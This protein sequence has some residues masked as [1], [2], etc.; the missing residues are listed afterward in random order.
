VLC[1]PLDALR[2]NRFHPRVLEPTP[3]LG[4][5]STIGSRAL[6]LRQLKYFVKVVETGNMTRAA[7]QIFVAQPAL[8]MQ[9]RQLEEDLG[10]ALLERHSRGVSP[11]RAGALLDERARAILAL[12]EDT[13]REVSACDRDQSETVRLGLTPA[14]MLVIGPELAVAARDRLPKVFLSLAEEMSHRLVDALTRGELDLVLA[15]DV[16][17]QSAFVRTALL[18][19]D[20]VLVMPPGRHSPGPVPFAEALEES[21]AMPE[22]R[23]TV[24]E[25]VIRTARDLGLEPK[26]GYEVR[27]IAAIK[28][29]V[30]RGAAAAILPY[31]SIHAEVRAGLLQ[32]RPIASPQLRRTLFLA[33]DAGRPPL[34]NELALTGVIREALVHLS[35][36]LGPLAHALPPRDPSA[37]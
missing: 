26:I 31:A 9:I 12:V 33:R 23:D 4:G 25:L 32:A 17:D 7:E 37:G 30:Q 18:Q 21:L 22:A 14:L 24:R 1:D 20:L 35:D 15:Y 8:G 27:S 11:T 10:V 5:L 2:H 29:L 28:H 13:R 36:V 3:P 6:N 34:R 19:D 16:P